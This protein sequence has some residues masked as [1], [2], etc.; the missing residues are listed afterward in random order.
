MTRLRLSWVGLI[1]ALVLLSPARPA[2]ATQPGKCTLLDEIAPSTETGFTDTL[3]S[4]SPARV[5]SVE[6]I[7]T[8]AN[9]YAEIYDAV[10]T[11]A[12]R[13]RV[14]EPGNATSNNHEFVEFGPE[15]HVTE[16][17]LGVFVAKGR[18]IVRWGR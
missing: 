12:T 9:G 8:S 16:Y 15:G 17:G 6:F 2:G 5:C 1:A 14:A 10:S 13:E 7:A 11:T 18:V 4:A 3:L